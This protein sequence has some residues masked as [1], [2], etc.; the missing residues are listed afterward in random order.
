[1][2]Y[3]KSNL[4][5][6]MK[7]IFLSFVTVAIVHLSAYSQATFIP[8]IGL[9]FARTSGDDISDEEA[10]TGLLVGA[11]FNLPLDED[12]ISLQ[13]EVL[14]IQKG[15]K[16]DGSRLRRRFNYVEVP[17][18]VK[19]SI[20][21]DQIKGYFNAGPSLGFGVSSKQRLTDDS[22][23]KVTFGGDPGFAKRID[24]GLQFGGGVGFEAGPGSLILDLRY[25]VGLLNVYEDRSLKN[26]ALALS[27]GYALPLGQ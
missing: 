5:N 23:G 10:K 12:L 26:R 24:V 22:Y 19:V 11:A 8:K 1:M 2:F 27:L 16:Q 20:G 14:Y 17:I 9:A 6:S 25:G 18:L 7:K 4:F 21:T 13:P 3:S 15:T